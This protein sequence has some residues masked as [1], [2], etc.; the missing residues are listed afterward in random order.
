MRRIAEFIVRHRKAVIV[1]FMAAVA[2][3]GVLFFTVQVNYDLAEYLPEGS[4]TQ[5]AIAEME[6]SFGSGGTVRVMVEEV[7]PAEA[8]S[9]KA[10]LTA[11]EGVKSVLWLDDAADL[12]QPLETL[13]AS[14]TEQFYKDGAA[15]FTVTFTESDYASLTGEA[16]AAIRALPIENVSIAGNAEESRNMRQVLSKE[17][18]QIFLIVVPF[19]LLILFFASNAWVEP[20]LYLFVLLVSI[21]INMGTNAFFDSV[22]FITH[23]M[24][25]VLQLAISLDYSLFLFHR[26]IEERDA[27]VAPKEAIVSAT[28]KSFSS[29]L[30]SALTTVAGFLALLLMSYTIGRDIGLVLAKGIVFSLLTVMLLMPALIYSM[31]GVIDKTRHKHWVPSFQKLGRGV[32]KARWVLLSLVI[33]IMIPAYLASGNNL[34][35]YGDN[36]G[37]AQGDTAAERNAIADRFGV[38][39]P[40]ALLVPVGD[41][42]AEVALTDE[43]LAQPAVSGIQSLVT[44]A[45]PTL[46]R[47]MLPASVTSQFESEKYSRIVV[48]LNIASEG[49]A[50]TEAVAR[51]TGAA[52]RH[53]P[54]QWLAAGSPTS[55]ADIKES[56]EGDGQRVQLLSILA[57][58]VIVLLAFRSF[59]IPVLLVA[60]IQFAIWINM[61]VPYFTGSSLVYIGYL[62]ISSLQLG[63][64]ID[65][66]ILL[67]NRYMEERRLSPPKEAAISA[68]C[69]AGPS[70]LVST[71]I[72]A[73]AGF[74]EALLSKVPSISEIGL[75]LGRGALLSGGMVL[76]VLPPLLAMLDKVIM[77]GTLKTK[78]GKI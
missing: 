56:V 29:V 45:D 57:V 37:S 35:L 72:L 22:S 21:V 34:F 55:L 73:G 60:L 5:N 46:P 48:M 71:L 53:Y 12:S 78:G 68:L 32:Y 49:P 64:T 28:V 40:V 4:M 74:A 36:S 65:Y 77:A 38:Y 61:A 24:A 13:D 18:L 14:L 44:L 10:R 63:A 75:L 66:A 30:S 23:A 42:A 17:I 59:T 20:P 76:L 11:V 1:I 51:L 69:H 16:I 62:V 52:E 3:C 26:Y 6:E 70:V 41:V 8:L 33:V 9:I 19:C 15:L 43:L 39:N 54:G 2:V 31:R 7:T 25:A 58:A 27:G 50:L 47:E 67:T